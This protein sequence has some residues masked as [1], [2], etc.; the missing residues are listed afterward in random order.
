MLSLKDSSVGIIKGN[1]FDI[2]DKQFVIATIQSVSMK[3]FPLAAFDSFGLVILM[4][5]ICTL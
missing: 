4:K 2:I 1:K 5:L 3:T